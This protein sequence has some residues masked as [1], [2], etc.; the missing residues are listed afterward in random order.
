[1]GDVV[2][3]SGPLL[4]GVGVLIGIVL[5]FGIP[6]A[7]LSELYSYYRSQADRCTEFEQHTGMCGGCSGSGEVV[8][9]GALRERCPACGGTGLAV[10]R[11]RPAAT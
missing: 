7:F 8:G 4:F 11:R 3:A 1:M 2:V 10:W 9:Y 6:A 5:V